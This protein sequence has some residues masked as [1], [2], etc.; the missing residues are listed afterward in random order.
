MNKLILN[1][2]F[3]LYEKCGKPFCS[4]RQ[5]AETFGRDHNHILRD[6]RNA[7][8]TVSNF[9]AQFWTANFIESQYKDRGKFYPEYLL[10]KDGFSYLA[11]GFTG[12]K[13]AAFKHSCHSLC[14]GDSLPPLE[15]F[16]SIKSPP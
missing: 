8:E 9:A 10:T 12:K 2:E 3:S 14:S 13:A 6:I 16:N 1:P 4:S 7:M 5:M 11:M 15:R